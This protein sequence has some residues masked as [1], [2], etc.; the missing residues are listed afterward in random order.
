LNEPAVAFANVGLRRG[1]RRIL[2][3][4]TFAI[5]PGEFVGVIGGNGA[6]KSTL[7]QIALGFL[8]PTEG[9]VRIFGA[10]PQA[11]RGTIGY[12]PQRIEMDADLPLRARDF[13][14]R[15]GLPFPSA[16]RRMRVDE[17]LAET[18]AL[19]LADRPVGRLSGGEQQRLAIALA[20]VGRPK[21]LL[22]D[23]PLANLDLGAASEVVAL[24]ARIARERGMTV[25]LVSHDLNPLQGAMDRILYLADGRAA[26][27]T[28]EEIVNEDTLSRLYDRPV[29][30]LH[31]RGR[32]VVLAGE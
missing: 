13:V 9:T 31:V 22:L 5:E 15:V 3:R 32:I 17:A 7:L 28:V 23:E 24:T 8:R 18:G 29:D 14:A 11:A 27:G 4:V 2:S 12:V 26:L 1:D 20:I 6:G 16:S 30:V 10:T 19:A 21:L 25:L